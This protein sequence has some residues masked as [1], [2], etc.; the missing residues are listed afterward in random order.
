MLIRIF[1]QRNRVTGNRGDCI[2]KSDSIGQGPNKE[3]HGPISISSASNQDEHFLFD[4]WID[5]FRG[6]RFD[7]SVELALFNLAQIA[8]DPLHAFDF[9]IRGL[10]IQDAKTLYRSRG[11]DQ[12]ES[13]PRCEHSK[14]NNPKSLET[15]SGDLAE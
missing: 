15:D 12:Q 13:G 10:D 9:V 2:D 5:T 4:H 1:D 8:F 6:Q 14:R 7:R 11:I 3:T